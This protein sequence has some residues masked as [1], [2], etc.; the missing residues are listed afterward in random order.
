MR[1]LERIDMAGSGHVAASGQSER[2]GDRG[3]RLVALCRRPFAIAS[4][5]MRAMCL[6]AAL[7]YLLLI[8]VCSSLSHIKALMIILGSK[9][10]YRKGFVHD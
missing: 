10:I 6:G 3:A 5:Q 7:S 2:R 8:V 1:I 9:T 4:L